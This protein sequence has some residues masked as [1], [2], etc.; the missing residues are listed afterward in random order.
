[1]SVSRCIEL[2]SGTLENAKDKA[3]RLR[4]ISEKRN[5]KTTIEFFSA[6]VFHLEKLQS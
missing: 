1:M 3:N 2:A 4:S 5:N 6:I